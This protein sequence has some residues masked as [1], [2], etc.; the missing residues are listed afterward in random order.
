MLGLLTGA[1]LALVRPSLPARTRPFSVVAAVKRRRERTIEREYR[2]AVA[3]GHLP[4]EFGTPFY[5][6]VP[7]PRWYR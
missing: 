7:R 2:R 1:R 4:R 6:E 5:K 3:S